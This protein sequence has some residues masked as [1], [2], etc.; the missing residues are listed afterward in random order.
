MYYYYNDY[1]ENTLTTIMTI[2]HSYCTTM[3]RLSAS[4][5]EIATTIDSLM[6]D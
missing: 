2:C 1:E 5:R 6:L 3:T 4:Q